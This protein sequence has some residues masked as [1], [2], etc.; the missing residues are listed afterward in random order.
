V[1]LQMPRQ[2]CPPYGSRAPP[3]INLP[4][5]RALSDRENV[6]IGRGQESFDPTPPRPHTRIPADTRHSSRG[7]CRG[8]HDKSA[9]ERCPSANCQTMAHARWSSTEC[10][11]LL[12]VV[13]PHPQVAYTPPSMLHGVV[14][15][16]A[17]DRERGVRWDEPARRHGYS[18]GT[19]QA[20][21]E[22]ARS[23]R[24]DLHLLCG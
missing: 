11:S 15:S 8:E 17:H 24:A 22:Y 9:G 12:A 3:D 5:E 20:V 10:S 21:L 16:A 2:R 23:G 1:A 6:R 19:T 13:A 18:K 14:N 7:E 4:S